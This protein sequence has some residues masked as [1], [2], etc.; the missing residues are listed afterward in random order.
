[1]KKKIIS[2]IGLGYVGLP[3]LQKL[4]KFY[5]VYGYDINIK[6]INIIKKKFKKLKVSNNVNIIKDSNIFIIAVPTPIYNNKKPNL[7]ILKNTTKQISSYVK[8]N[9]LIIYE[10]TVY[11]GTTEEIC[12]PIIEKISKLIL[13]KDFSVGYSPER[14]NPGDKKHNLENTVKIISAS[15][16][17]SLN[18]LQ[19]IYSKIVKAGVHKV[20]N[21][22]TAESVKI[23]ENVQRDIN[24]AII[25]EFSKIFNALN[26]NTNEI[27]KAASTKWNFINL[28]PGLVGGHCIGVDPYYLLHKSIKIGQ[29]TYLIENARKINESMTSYIFENLKLIT[30]TKNIDLKKASILFLGAT[31]KENCDDIRNSKSLELASHLLK[32]S[33]KITIID[34]HFKN[35]KLKNLKIINKIPNIKYDILLI[36]VAHKEFINNGFDYYLNYLKNKNIIFDLKNIFPG[37][38]DFNL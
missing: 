31:F 4:N 37:K 18:I 29:K 22:K 23:I 27:I 8:K 38:S 35:Y 36:A 25:N 13:N 12:V 9:S 26:L 28:K 21:I 7:N 6:K 17:K 15:N 30:K 33:K 2:I 16:R 24:I 32:K 10:S 14:I 1:M 5:E 20:S 11:P 34:P 3:L 19:V